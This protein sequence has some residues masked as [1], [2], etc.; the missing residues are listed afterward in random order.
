[1]Q[2]TQEI[3]TLVEFDDAVAVGHDL[4]HAVL[5]SLDLTSRE[6]VLAH[7]RVD[8]ALFMGCTLSDA[9]ADDLRA[10]G[11]LLFP[12]IPDSPLNPYRASLYRAVNLYDTMP[13]GSY[14]DSFDAKAY[15]WTRSAGAVPSLEK[16]LVASLHDHAISDALEEY[17]AGLCQQRVVGIM[18]GHAMERGSEGYATTA[19][20]GMELAK[21]GFLVASGGGPGAM[22]AANLGARL[23]PHGTEALGV[24][25]AMLSRVPSFRPSIDD[26]VRVAF[27]V[28]DRFAGGAD[29]LG[30]PT[31]FYGHEP[32]NAFATRIAK[33]C[34]NAVREAT[35]L[36][37]CRG[38]LIFLPG[39]AGTVQELFQAVTGNYYASD[40]ATLTPL[41]LVGHEQ[42]T[43][44][45]PAWPLLEALAAGRPMAGAISLVE[46]IEEA[47]DWLAARDSVHG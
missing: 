18:G 33:Y 23:A 38:G 42:W 40:P 13:T 14:A 10:R 47:G 2:E 27:D 5:Q 36:E 24:A 15:A 9:A 25:L 44:S 30:V 17:L 12:R 16:T 20:L 45:L 4:A 7:C 32:P 21:A 3:E 31:W 28:K 29:T 26:W 11:A 6:D 1:M 37:L 39:A 46:T 8:A 41:V 35:L 19:A 34:S 22:E 43:R